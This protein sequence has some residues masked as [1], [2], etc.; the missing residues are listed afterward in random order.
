MMTKW[1]QGN[2]AKQ[3][4]ASRYQ[5]SQQYE[6]APQEHSI[7]TV[8]ER[9]EKLLQPT[10]GARLAEDQSYLIGNTQSNLFLDYKNRKHLYIYS[11]VALT[12]QLNDIGTYSVPATTW[13]DISFRPNMQIFT[14]NQA[15]AVM[16][17]VKATDETISGATGG[18]S[19]LATNVN[20]QQ[21]GGTATPAGEL[22]ANISQFGGLATQMG[23]AASQA[24]GNSPQI[25]MGLWDGGGS[26]N[27]WASA[28]GDNRSPNN[29][30]SIAAALLNSGGNLDR[31]RGNLDNIT[32]LASASQTTT[33]TTTDQ[34]NYNARGII[35]T[36]DAT[37]N[38]G[39]LGSIT[40][41]IDAKD[42]VSGKYVALLTGAAVV[43]VVTNIYIVYP[44]ATTVANATIGTALPRT[45]R[46]KVTANNANPVT[47][48]VAASL[49]V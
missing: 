10:G 27:V 49:I 46:V 33:Q 20:I 16:V 24:I 21:V 37:V 28:G 48:S 43:S 13:T 11:A 2:H 22:P 34:T 39:G 19:G 25:V 32:L 36:L 9:I 35:V 7:L 42:P 8:L 1:Y 17:Y 38:A 4:E 47:Y 41:E 14:T 12:L 18:S 23:S 44:G 29:S 3:N 40:L 26:Q 6:Q 15:T 30:A 31:A 5:L 45:W